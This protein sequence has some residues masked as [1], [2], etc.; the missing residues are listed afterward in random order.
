MTLVTIPYIPTDISTPSNLQE[1]YYFLEHEVKPHADLL[2]KDTVQLTNI[3]KIMAK[4]DV[5]GVDVPKQLGGL[6]LDIPQRH[7]FMRNIMRASAALDLLQIQHQSA[8][9]A[10]ATTSNKLLQQQYL[11]KALSGE[12]GIGIAY[13]HLRSSLN[14]PPV[15]SISNDNGYIVSG[16][17]RFVTG[18]NIFQ[19][20]EIGFINE[21]DEEIIAII[22]FQNTKDN[23][24]NFSQPLDLPAGKSTQT[25]SIEI[26]KLNVP[27][28]SVLLKR[29]K[30]TFYNNS[31][32]RFNLESLHAGM[33]LAI[34]DLIATSPRIK[35]K[36]IYNFY[37]DLLTVVKEYE[38]Q[39]ILRNSEEWVSPVRAQGILLVN[40]C[41]IFA[42]Q[43]FRGVGVN[44]QHPLIRLQNEALLCSSIGADD[45]LMQELIKILKK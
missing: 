6:L 25:I 18:Y 37:N 3:F 1:F 22:P 39:I 16:T 13:S 24:L 35:E 28:D 42:S 4:F 38:T 12:I 21:F 14:N 11:A 23:Q 8:V 33:A 40:Q 9:K 20:L 17:A 36:F 15:K 7:Y 45:H 34:L 31:L 30:G 2:D 43:I 27:H 10:L 41:L 32:T 26:N 29:P 19:Y 5:L 44:N